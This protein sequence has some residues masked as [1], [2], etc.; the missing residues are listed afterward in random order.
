VT[1]LSAKAHDHEVHA[2]K[3]HV[4]MLC[5]IFFESLFFATFVLAYLF[6]VGKSASGPQPDETL[7]L[8]LVI[9]NT[10]CLLASSVTVVI[11]VR[12]L[13]RG[14][15][16]RFGFWLVVTILLGLEFLAGTA[17]EWY[18]LI[19]EDQLTIRTNLFGSTFYT[20]VGF[21]AAHVCIGLTMLSLILIMTILGRVGIEHAEKV[22]VVSWYWH[23]VDCV[24]VVVF[25]SVYLI[26]R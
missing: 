23:F 3:G 24:W 7:K 18:G 8:P 12:H 17:Y 2:S 20:L 15:T 22:D 1:T 4:G 11:A 5:L 13:R 14:Q 16:L 19:Y 9:V 26:G 6:Y 10:I 21:H 25:T